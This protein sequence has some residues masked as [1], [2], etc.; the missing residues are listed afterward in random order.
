MANI[1]NSQ[2]RNLKKNAF[3]KKSTRV[4]LTPMVDLGF[5]L[6]TFFVF[7][8]TLS[9]PTV[10]NLNMP[11]DKVKPSDPICESCVLTIFLTAN[12]IIKYYEGFPGKENIIKETTFGKSGIKEIILQKRKKVQIQKGSSDDFV[13]IIKPG[14]ESSFQNFV[15]IVDEVAINDV[16]HYYT[17][18]TD[19][20]DLAYL[21]YLK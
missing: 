19:N 6:I 10:M 14:K 15:D 7:T 12:N 20:S 11:Y 3:V 2:G 8:T 17:S 9:T 1:E 13:M 18:E 16:K 21:N 4:D 5:L